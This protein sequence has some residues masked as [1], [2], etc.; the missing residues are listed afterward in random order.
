[1]AK[2]S[3]AVPE[4]LQKWYDRIHNAE[5]LRSK[6][7][8]QYGWDRIRRQLKGE[9][10]N[11]I[12]GLKGTPI[13]P[14]NLVHAFIRTAVP[15][16][17][18]R[19]P[20][21]AVNPQGKQYID[22]AKIVEPALNYKWRCLG[23]KR[24]MRKV[25]GDTL[26]PYGHGWIKTGYTAQ[27]EEV[28]K[29]KKKKI[30]T[31]TPQY[32]TDTIIK[33]EQIW[34]YRVSPKHITFNN[35]EAIDPP[36]DCRWI[37]HELLKPLETVKKL[38]PGNDDLK[39]S[40]L[41]TYDAA[42]DSEGNK[43]KNFTGSDRNQSYDRSGIP[44]VRMY[45]ITDMDTGMIQLLAEDFYKPLIDPRSFPYKF[46][47]FNF[48]MLKFNE[49]NDEPYPYSDIFAAEPQ[50]WE[51][52]KLLSMALNHVKRFNR[53]LVAKKNS[54]DKDEKA[55][56]TQG[57]DGM[58]IETLDGAPPV[59]INYPQL[60]P[61]IYNILD[62]LQMIFDSI[63]GQSAF[64]RGST[65]QTKTR[66]LG[67]V[68]DIQRSTGSR[69]SEKLDLVEDFTE[70]I[71]E[72]IF[73]LMGQYVDVPEWV[74]VTGVDPA[75]LNQI[76]Q[77]PSAD[78]VGQMADNT[79]F[80]YTKKDL[81]GKYGIRVVAGSTKPLDF[82]YRNDLLMQILKVG[83]AVG[84]VPGSQAS[85]EIGRELFN[86]LDMFGV[87][88]AYED[89]IQMQAMQNQMAQLAQKKQQLEQQV[90][91]LQQKG[92]QTAAQI[93]QGQAVLTQLNQVIAAKRG[94]IPVNGGQGAV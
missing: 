11:V 32:E 29:N 6:I 77:P 48:S 23:L 66:T 85:N 67:E 61:D 62:R 17:Y 40:F 59:A 18:F 22:K 90:G 58:L 12:G 76:L 38:F 80:Y 25:L 87:E 79:G 83:Q 45:E 36:Y 53:Q 27:A 2:K 16:L 54:L 86:N 21:L 14:V 1:M 52:V 68:K 70:E 44:M 63:V 46:K 24:E 33:G 72:K 51:I 9:Y 35:D 47:G 84:I 13:I 89:Q 91:Q 50:I 81:Q 60:Q 78:M 8:N 42:K 92:Q 31:D 49:V 65:T 71:A 28:P 19:D 39:A 57:I 4:E 75:I 26:G 88:K 74:S 5:S 69:S 15:S 10:K 7:A 64:D 34:A 37:A 56:L 82:D 93:Q 94:A 3:T 41:T 43:V 73:S 20:R 30:D 55:K